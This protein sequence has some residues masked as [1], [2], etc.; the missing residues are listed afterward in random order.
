MA[1]PSGAGTEVLR[2]N[3]IA[4]QSTTE[5]SIDWAQAIQTAAG[6]TSGTTAVPAEAIIT[7]LNIIWCNRDANSR[8][9]DLRID[10]AS[11]TAIYI[12]LT[13]PIATLQTFVFSDKLVLREGDILKFD[14]SG[15][16]VDIRLNYIYQAF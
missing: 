6:N 11:G 5:T 3:G 10:H 1:I 12:M 2:R 13:Q 7:V 16:D 14:M 8:T 9:F 4:G 15:S